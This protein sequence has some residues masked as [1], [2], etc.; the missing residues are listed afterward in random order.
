MLPIPSSTTT[1][2]QCSIQSTYDSLLRTALTLQQLAYV[3]LAVRASNQINTPRLTQLTIKTGISNYQSRPTSATHNDCPAAFN[4]STDLSFPQRSSSCIQQLD[5]P[6]LPTTIIQLHPTTR[7]ISATSSDHLAA[8]IYDSTIP[9]TDI[10]H[11]AED[12][13]T[14]NTNFTHALVNTTINC[15]LGYICYLGFVSFIVFGC[16]NSQALNLKHLRGRHAY[17]LRNTHT[18]THT[19]TH[20]HTHTHIYIY[21]YIY[22]YIMNIVI[23]ACIYLSLIF[24]WNFHHKTIELL[25]KNLIILIHNYHFSGSLINYI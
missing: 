17:R 15:H 3:R 9:A 11:L 24:L 10:L 22:I 16:H 6:Q 8:H 23:L 13:N 7:P 18:H 5:Q 21:I 25:N 19:Y 2:Q 4:N 1:L 20:T 14:T 12:T